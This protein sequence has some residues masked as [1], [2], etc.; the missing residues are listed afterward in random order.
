MSPAEAIIVGWALLA[1]SC[2]LLIR[3]STRH[4]GSAS[5]RPPEQTPSARL[6]ERHDVA[7]R[8]SM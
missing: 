8:D 3:A 5:V 4:T 1:L 6:D 7:D 2:L